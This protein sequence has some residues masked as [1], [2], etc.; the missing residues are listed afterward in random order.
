MPGG[1][2]RQFSFVMEAKSVIT[3]PSAGMKLPG[4]G[5]YEIQGLAWSGRGKIA[6]VD[7]FGGR[8]TDL[9]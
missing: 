8:G 6:A 3:R 4:P 9:A 2:W 1:K 5:F 7:V